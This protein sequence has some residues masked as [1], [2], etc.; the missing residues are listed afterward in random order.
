MSFYKF[1]SLPD[2]HK[3]SALIKRKI[4]KTPIRTSLHL[5]Y[6][7]SFNARRSKGNLN[8]QSGIELFFKLENLQNTGSFKF[9]GASHFLAR[10]ED[11]ELLNGVVTYSTGKRS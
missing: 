11:H 4:K 7:A 8:S 2:V 1:P 5:S 3:A 9:R 6:I 10:L